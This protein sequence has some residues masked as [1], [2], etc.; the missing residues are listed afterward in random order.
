MQIVSNYFV[1]DYMRP[2]ISKDMCDFANLGKAIKKNLSL[3][4][5][6]TEHNFKTVSP[7]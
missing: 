4:N 7:F 6:G 5:V 2:V 1:I 3:A